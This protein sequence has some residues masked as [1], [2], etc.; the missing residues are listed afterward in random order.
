MREFQLDRAHAKRLVSSEFWAN[1]GCSV[2]SPRVLKARASCLSM[3]NSCVLFE[4]CL[5]CFVVKAAL[6]LAYQRQQKF[7]VIFFLLFFFFVHVFIFVHLGM[8][9]ASV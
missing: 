6:C 5:V 1:A 7:P 3:V 2:R 4:N 9:L 8:T